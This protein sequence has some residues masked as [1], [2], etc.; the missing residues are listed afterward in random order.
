MAKYEYRGQ[1][2]QTFQIKPFPLFPIFPS[3]P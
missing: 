3:F 2:T 1:A